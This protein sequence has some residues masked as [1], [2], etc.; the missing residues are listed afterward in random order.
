MG[1]ILINLFLLFNIDI[2]IKKLKY[3]LEA[4]QVMR[5]KQRGI[6]L[7]FVDQG[8]GGFTIAG[9]I[10]KLSIDPT[11]HLKSDT[12][13]ECSGGVEIGKYFHTGRGLTIFSVKHNYKDATKIPYDEKIIYEKVKIEDFVWCGC[14][15]TILSGVTVGEGA[16]IAASSLISKNIP[17]YAIV[18]GNPAKIIKYRD[19]NKFMTLKNNNCYF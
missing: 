18:G 15:V 14:N 1:R 10:T 13:I 3:V 2:F 12:F 19:I 5:L 16:I 8:H 4:C 6:N 11:S 7:N 9:D 17:P